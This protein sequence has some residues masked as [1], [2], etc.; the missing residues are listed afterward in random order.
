MTWSWPQPFETV[1]HTSDMG[2]RVRGASAEETLARLVLGFA[3]LLTGGPAPVATESVH[4]EIPASEDPALIAVDA[5]REMHA[6]FCRRR[7]IA[8]EVADVTWSG[9]SVHLRVVVGPYDPDLHAEGSD[10]KAVTYHAARF[11]PNGDELMAQVLLD[12]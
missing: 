10:I 5:L 8:L 6:L 11:E 2:V 1:D 3:E 9:E 4:L 7:L 12:V